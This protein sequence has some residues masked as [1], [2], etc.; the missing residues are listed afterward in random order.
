MRR[1]RSTTD[2]ALWTA[3]VFW[4]VFFSIT[5]FGKVLCY[6]TAMWQEVLEDGLPWFSAVPQGLFVFIGVCE[7]VGGVGLIL[8]AMTGV[9]P[10][11]T[12]LAAFGLTLIM[13]LAAVF[14]VARGEYVFVPINLL[15]GGVA[16]SSR[17]DA[18]S[19][20]LSGTR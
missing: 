6:D 10:K 9:K 20:G 8:P 13:I 5:G 3:Q 17:M 4:G 12:P 14:H 19:S 11:L 15:L 7:L 16:G 18:C 1:P 2:I